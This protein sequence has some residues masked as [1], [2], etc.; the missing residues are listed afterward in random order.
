MIEGSQIE[1]A[2]KTVILDFM[3]LKEG[4]FMARK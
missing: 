4:P 3:G 1:V 2:F